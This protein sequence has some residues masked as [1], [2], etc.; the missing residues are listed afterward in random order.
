MN[1][2]ARRYLDA[3]ILDIREC[4]RK[5]EETLRLLNGHITESGVRDEAMSGKLNITDRKVNDHLDAHKE[6]R[7]WMA[8]LWVGLILALVGAAFAAIK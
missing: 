5:Q 7:G 6:N 1:D 8:T 4:N 2:E 3:I